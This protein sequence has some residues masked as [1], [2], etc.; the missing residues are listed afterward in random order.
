MSD[1]RP[2]PRD[3]NTPDGDTGADPGAGG[4]RP[5][6]PPGEAPA[7]G[8]QPPSYGQ[9]SASSGQP[10]YGQQPSYGQ[11][12]PSFGQQSPDQGQ[13]W[14]Q[15]GYG[16]PAYGQ[17]GYGQPGY[18]QPTRGGSGLA[19]AA[20]VLGILAL[21][22]FITI[23]GGIALGLVAV[24]LGFIARGKARAGT[25]SGSGLALGGIITGLIGMLL[26]LAFGAFLVFFANEVSECDPTLPE[27]ELQ[28]CIEDQ[29]LN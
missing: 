19:V 14:G 1:Q 24:I 12:P 18:A 22:S 11:Q 7:Y 20:L 3:P 6:D 25:G 23:I 10:A 8:Q 21:L 29:L 9:H 26:A 5:M 17:P 28:Q 16:Q 2:G 27:A 15:P 4:A 13:A